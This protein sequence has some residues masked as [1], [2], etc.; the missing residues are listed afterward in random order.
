MIAAGERWSQVARVASPATAYLV[1][2]A[3][4]LVSVVWLRRILPPAELRSALGFFFIAA[5]SAGL[6]PAT[7]KARALLS[8]RAPDVR[9]VATASAIKAL[10][11]TPILALVWKL[12]DPDLPAAGLAW[13]VPTVVAGFWATEFRV[14][15]DLQGRHGAAIWLKQGSLA[16]AF[17]GAALGLAAGL[18]IGFALALATAPRLIL[19]LAVAR[20]ARRRQPKSTTAMA[21]WRDSGWMAMALTSALAAGGGSIDRMLGLRLLPAEVFAGYYLL[22]EFLSRFWVLPYLATPILFARLAGGRQSE[23]LNRSLWVG[24]LLAGAGLVAVAAA[25]V[26]GAPRTLGAL[27]GFSPGW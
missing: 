20:G 1:T 26:A 6:E 11:A 12:A 24:C 21:L 15:L 10:A 19:P 8:A 4:M 17:L 27:L 5:L 18:P 22:Y 14:L 3:A 13:L 2:A 7:V 23:A 16:L 25:A 9:A